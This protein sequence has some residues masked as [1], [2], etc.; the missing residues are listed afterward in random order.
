MEMHL[1]Y[2]PVCLGSCMCVGV[3]ILT[4]KYLRQI[5]SQYIFNS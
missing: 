1:N 2:V 3:G 4:L 5:N